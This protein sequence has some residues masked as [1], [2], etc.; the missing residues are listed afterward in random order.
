LQEDYSWRDR[1]R[2]AFGRLPFSIILD[3]KNRHA[4][5]PR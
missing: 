1:N 3:V 5:I 4:V 2:F